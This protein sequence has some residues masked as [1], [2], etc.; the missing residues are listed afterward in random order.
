M[1]FKEKIEVRIPHTFFVQ[2][3]SFDDANLLVL[4]MEIKKKLLDAGIPKD[5][6]ITIYDDEFTKD[7]VYV[8]RR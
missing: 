3:P 5:A 6:I 8:Y 2:Y 1:S 4:R 7:I